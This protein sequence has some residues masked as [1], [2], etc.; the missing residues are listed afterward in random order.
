[1]AITMRPWITTMTAAG[2]PAEISMLRPPER[3]KPNSTAPAMTP[4]AEPRARRP[5][6]SPS[7]P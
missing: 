4:A 6:T 2:T 1:M 7:N 5:T 3:R